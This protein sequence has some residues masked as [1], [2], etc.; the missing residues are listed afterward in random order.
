MNKSIDSK[1]TVSFSYENC[2]RW[3]NGWERGAWQARDDY[4]KSVLQELELDV[5]Y[6]EI[7]CISD[8]KLLTLVRE[9]SIYARTAE[10]KCHYLMTLSILLFAV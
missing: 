4:T 3:L 7:A 8:F 1:R 5:E 10:I 9:T 2:G 6:N